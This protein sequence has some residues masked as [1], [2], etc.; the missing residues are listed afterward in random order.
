MTA[1][2]AFPTDSMLALEITKIHWSLSD[3]LAGDKP[4][5]NGCWE[6]CL[7]MLAWME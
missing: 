2:V 3:P 5:M 6:R 1:S 7:C 4:A